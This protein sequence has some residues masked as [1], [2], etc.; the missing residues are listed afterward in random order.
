MSV[1]NARLLDSNQDAHEIE[2]FQIIAVLDNLVRL[3]RQ[4]STVCKRVECT[5]H[6][7]PENS[8]PLR[9]NLF[10]FDNYMKQGI[11]VAFKS[12]TEDSNTSGHNK[13]S[14]KYVLTWPGFNNAEYVEI[15]KVDVT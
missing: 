14:F 6:V 5:V 1:F 11:K 3:Q 7:A 9:P 8:L 2:S 12:F 15:K 4:N 13:V 10:V